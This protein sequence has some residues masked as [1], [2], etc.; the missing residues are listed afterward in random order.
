MKSKLLVVSTDGTHAPSVDVH[1][2]GDLL[3]L[4]TSLHDDVFDPDA[5]EKHT[6]AEM[7]KRFNEI[8]SCNKT[9]FYIADIV[10]GQISSVDAELI[11]PE[12]VEE[13]L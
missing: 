8:D 5:D 12:N 6:A 10:D 1:A 4:I 3:T 11:T 7:L 2:L 9:W 13:Y